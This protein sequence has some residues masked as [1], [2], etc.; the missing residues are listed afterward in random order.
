MVV[1]TSTCSGYQVD[2]GQEK[3]HKI[4]NASFIFSLDYLH[5]YDVSSHIPHSNTISI[6]FTET[7][8]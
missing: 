1:R 4:Q 8:K 7:K 6:D 5:F 3:S 2:D